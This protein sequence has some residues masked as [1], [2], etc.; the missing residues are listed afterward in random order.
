MVTWSDTDP[1]FRPKHHLMR[2]RAYSVPV[3]LVA[4]QM[5][6]AQWTPLGSGLQSI[7]SITS[8]G[9]ALYA[10]TYPS[11]V[12]KS[13][14]NGA[15]WNQANNGLPVSGTSVFC[16]SV[17]RNATHLFAGTHSGI[18]RSAN[19][20]ADWEIANGTLTATN[21][22]YADKF[23]TFNNVTF[24]VFAG[25]VANGGG[26]WRTQNSGTTWT[27]G[28]SG[29]GSNVRVHH[30]TQVGGTLYASTSTGVW[31]STDLGLSWTALSSVNYETF[32]LAASGGDLAIASVFGYR[33]S[34]NNGSTWNDATGDPTGPTS[35]EMI[36]FNGG[37]IALTADATGCVRS[38]DGGMTW[39]PYNGGFSAI[40]VN[41]LEEFHIDGNLLYVGAL[42]DVYSVA[43]SGVGMDDVSAFHGRVYPSISGGEY[44]IELPE[45]STGGILRF[46]DASGRIAKAIR[47][48][49]GSSVLDATALA[50]GAYVLELVSDERSLP[51]GR[52]IKE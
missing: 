41:A 35:G 39:S 47:V 32:S 12:R 14:D 43:G 26:I 46:L 29:M 30:M 2:I 48:G 7:R 20:G 38:L 24:A 1:Y 49:A 17:G 42:F 37:L 51:M 28:H 45:G 13:T 33:Y 27:I 10:A 22:V 50:P 34:T 18:Y 44:R 11:G 16:E 21:Q 40:D 52:V 25:T 9:G 23:F 5:V 3:L 36:A 8:Q 19:G 31:T 15:T 4:S 6:L